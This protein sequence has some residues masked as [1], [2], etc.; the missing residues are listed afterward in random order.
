MSRLSKKVLTILTGPPGAGK[1]EYAAEHYPHAVIYEQSADNKP[2]L[3]EQREGSAVLIT[4]APTNSAK[5]YWVEEGK[6]FGFETTV[7]VLCG[8]RTEEVARLIKR[9][10][11]GIS[12]RQR[13]RVAK[14]VGRWYCAYEPYEHEVRVSARN[15][16][17]PKANNRPTAA[18]R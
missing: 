12:Q 7:V 16:R 1:E 13:D 18:A 11:P 8:N 17:I 5:R 9:E 2:L 14:R 15:T 10:R 4:V 6:R 3:R